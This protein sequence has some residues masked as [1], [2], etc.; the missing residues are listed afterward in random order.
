MRLHLLHSTVAAPA[1]D[2]RGQLH[3]LRPGEPSGGAGAVRMRF[4]RPLRRTAIDV[5]CGEGAAC[6]VPLHAHEALQLLLPTSRFAV[7]DGLGRATTIDPGLVH[8]TNP[9]ELQGARGLGRAPFG[10]CVMLVLAPSVATLVGDAPTARREEPPQPAPG[11]VRDPRLAAELRALFDALRGPLVSLD[12]EA[13]LLDCVARLVARRDERRHE[14]AGCDP[15]HA[16]VA[17]VRDRLRAYVAE[18]VTLGELAA[19]AG[20]SRF[21]LLRA[22]RRAYGLTPHAYQ[23][24]LRLARARRMLAD[25][26]PLSHVTYDAGFADQSHLTRRFKSFFGLTPA[27]YARQVTTPPSA[28]ARQ[29]SYAVQTAAPL[30]AA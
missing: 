19:I 16:G 21:Y 27:Q 2:E 6:E 11:V 25:G 26:R 10:M 13:R 5:V 12:C 23:M 28:A 18:P 30:P 4:W 7:V 22:F 14:S 24:Q 9:F 1:P 17:R 3:H 20:L 29:A 15:Q 8:L